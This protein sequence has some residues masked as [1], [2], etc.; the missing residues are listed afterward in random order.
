MLNVFVVFLGDIK[1]KLTEECQEDIKTKASW[2]KT[3]NTMRLCQVQLKCI[4]N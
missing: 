4:L 3:Y 1:S 2:N